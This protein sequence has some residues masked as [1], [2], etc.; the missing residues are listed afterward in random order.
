[1]NF[2]I[3]KRYILSVFCLASAVCGLAQT[4][5][6]VKASLD[7]VDIKMGT[8]TTLHLKVTQPKNIKGQFPLLSQIRNDGII[9]ICGDS[10]E[11]RSPS[12]IDTVANG[13]I[14]T[15]NY[16]IPLQSFD[17]GYYKLP[18]FIYRF[19]NDSVKSNSL[20]LRVY[21]VMAQADTPIHDYAS[22]ADPENPSIFDVIPDWII[23][24]WWLWIIT[25][26]AIAV[27]F[28]AMRKYKRDGFV[29]PKKPE[30]TPYEAA[31]NALH[32]LKEKKLWEQGLEK[33][34]FTELTE[35]LRIYLFRRFG[36]NA[37]EMTSRQIIAS[38][39]ENKEIADKRDYFRQILNMADFVKFAKVRPLPDDNVKAF[40]NAVRFVEETKPADKPEE[41]P[42]DNS[43]DDNSKIMK[44][45]DR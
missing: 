39:R 17:S 2:K 40:E 26:L 14:L 9:S 42:S 20:G 33:D 44:G 15:I 8:I 7:S 32:A 31:I 6:N 27:F 35:I 10:V 24:L 22:V 16:D 3:L 21:P 13:N 36:I 41:I 37:M 11:L 4:N 30:P 38:L 23:D 34:Y 19:A 43:S 12:K 1:M 25:V 45:G 5:V 28:Y 29:L 18:E